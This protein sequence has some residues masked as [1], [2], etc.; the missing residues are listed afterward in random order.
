MKEIIRD[1]L[2]GR[3]S[4]H[5][6]TETVDGDMTL[7]EFKDSASNLVARAKRMDVGDAYAS[8]REQMGLTTEVPLLTTV[9]LAAIAPNEGTQ[10]FD[11]TSMT[12]CVYARG[13]WR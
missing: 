1:D 2:I 4:G 8:I 5:T 3:N 6:F 13:A 7:V 12:P 9:E 11:V 10:A